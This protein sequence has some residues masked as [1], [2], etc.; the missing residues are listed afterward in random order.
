MAWLTAATWVFMELCIEVMV[1]FTDEIWL[2]S[3][4]WSAFCPNAVSMV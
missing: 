2:L 1:L 4:V 3:E